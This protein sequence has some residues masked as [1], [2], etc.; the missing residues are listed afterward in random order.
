MQAPDAEEEITTLAACGPL[1]T[2]S[3]IVTVLGDFCRARDERIGGRELHAL[4]GRIGLT[5]PTVRVAL[6][7][8]KR[9]G[10]LESA[11]SGRDAAYRLSAM[12][13][14]ET[15]TVRDRIYAREAR[16]DGV[17]HMVL[18]PPHLAAPDFAAL[19]PR[20][21]V[22]VGP[23]SAILCDLPKSL[24]PELWV[25]R[26]SDGKPPLWVAEMVADADLRRDYATLTESV[27]D[28][29]RAPAPQ[30]ALDRSALRLLTLHHWRRL[31]L[32]HGDL[33]DIL[34]GEGWEGARARRA[35][36]TALDRFPRPAPGALAG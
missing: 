15:Q 27:S 2:W 35:V 16:R 7:R 13:W 14:R 33:P 4:L 12:G 5:A 6:H 17:A 30:S 3:V 18:A 21:A 24:P 8:L 1:K 19:L 32:R 36:M 10:W 22:H 29:L 23:R 34:L 20:E 25:T 26:L 11:K 31:R 9:D 28:I